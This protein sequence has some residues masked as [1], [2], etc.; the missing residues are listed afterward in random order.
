M[1]I[2][3]W[4]DL[5]SVFFLWFLC[6]IVFFEWFRFLRLEIGKGGVRRVYWGLDVF[7]DEVLDVFDFLVIVDFYLFY[8]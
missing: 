2:L 5:G 8:K 4:F 3:I 1:E 7:L 6:C